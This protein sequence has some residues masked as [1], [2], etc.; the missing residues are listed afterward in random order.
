MAR[1]TFT[2]Y[3]AAYVGNFRIAQLLIEEFGAEVDYEAG[4][5]GTALQAA[6]YQGDEDTVEILLEHGANPFAEGGTCGSPLEAAAGKGYQFILKAF[7]NHRSVD[8]A[9]K[10]VMRRAWEKAKSLSDELERDS[11]VGL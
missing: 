8:E 3:A 10:R 6:A 1:K 4:P 7:L 5:F 2:L 11:I 9:E